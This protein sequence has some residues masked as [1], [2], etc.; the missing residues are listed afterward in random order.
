MMGNEQCYWKDTF[1]TACNPTALYGNT[2]LYR[3]KPFFLICGLYKIAKSKQSYRNQL[4]TMLSYAEVMEA[5]KIS[6]GENKNWIVKYYY[7]RKKAN[8]LQIISN[9]DDELILDDI[10]LYQEPVMVPRNRPD[11]TPIFADGTEP[12]K[13]KPGP[14]SGFA[15]LSIFVG[16]HRI[17]TYEKTEMEALGE[18]YETQIINTWGRRARDLMRRDREERGNE[19]GTSKRRNRSKSP[20]KKKNKIEREQEKK[21]DKGKDQKNRE[22]GKSKELGDKNNNKTEVEVKTEDEQVEIQFIGQ[23]SGQILNKE[24]NI[25]YDYDTEKNHV[26]TEEDRKKEEKNT[27]EEN[28]KGTSFHQDIEDRQRREELVLAEIELAQKRK[29]LIRLRLQAYQEKINKEQARLDRIQAQ[30]ALAVKRRGK[31]RK[32]GKKEESSSSGSNSESSSD[33]GSSGEED[34]TEK[35]DTKETE[36]E[37]EK[38]TQEEPKKKIEQEREIEITGDELDVLMQKSL[39]KVLAEAEREKETI[40]EK[41]QEKPAQEEVEKKRKREDKEAN[42]KI[43]TEARYETPDQLTQ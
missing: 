20:K 37:K 13:I 42:K 2:P 23:Y 24:D 18:D 7:S 43:R 17:H 36:K 8:S 40:K 15:H 14:K 6:L 27:N 26:Q 41:E 38:E 16:T 25:K 30:I 4:A 11:D 3:F 39:K 12:P 22:R 34:E 5:V 31:M 21:E 1:V 9:Q 10:E 29:E 33:T 32:K 35:D 28:M 19:P